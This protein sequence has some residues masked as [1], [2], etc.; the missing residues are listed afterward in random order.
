M[1]EQTGFSQLFLRDEELRLGFELLLRAQRHLTKDVQQFLTEMGL[2]LAD[3][4]IL[5]YMARFPGLSGRELI[6]Q[7]G[8]TKQSLSRHLA[9][10]IN[11]ALVRTTV[12]LRDRRQ[13]QHFLTEAGTN[14]ENNL[15]ERERRMIAQAYR[16]AGADAV[17]GF[18]TVLLGLQPKTGL[19][20]TH[21]TQTERRSPPKISQ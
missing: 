19:T 20:K 10:L 12:N 6:D 16:E 18:R 17:I 2:S 15:F 11:L 14:L 8:M 3:R 1:K 7:V 5:Y 4:P 21:V 9:Q 13:T